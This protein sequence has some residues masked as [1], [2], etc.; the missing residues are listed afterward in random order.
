MDR[1]ATVGRE[2]GQEQD[3]PSGRLSRHQRDARLP[4]NDGACDQCN[5]AVVVDAE[6]A[7]SIVEPRP[8]LVEMVEVALDAIK[9]ACKHFDRSG[10]FGLAARLK[11]DRQ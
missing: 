5:R 3:E 11:L 8:W 9:P 6:R 1:P 10:E 4:A 7:L 2:R